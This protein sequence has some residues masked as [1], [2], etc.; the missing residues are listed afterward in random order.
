M[1]TL[2]VVRHGQASFFAEDYDKLSEDGIAQSRLLGEYWLRWGVRFDRVYI[3]PRRRHQETHDAVAAVYAEHGEAWPTPEVLPGLDEYQ[4]QELV[5]AAVPLLIEEDA[6]VRKLAPK[7]SEGGRTFARAFQLLFEHITRMWLREELEVDGIEPW[8][9]FRAR[10]K[11]ALTQMR[12]CEQGGETVVAFTSGGPVAASVG[13]ALGLT[14]QEILELSWQIYNAG[15]NEY[16]FSG[17]RFTLRRL[18]ATPH[19]TEPSWLTHR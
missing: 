1:S 2:F 3:G 11:D 6:V 9:A 7:L 12:H 18:N 4:A 13:D 8:A 10:M 19:L 15:Y 14:D 16:V 17:E 5:K